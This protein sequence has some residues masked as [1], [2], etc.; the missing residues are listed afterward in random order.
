[1]RE[2]RWTYRD[3]LVRELKTLRKGRGLTVSKMKYCSALRQQLNVPTVQA[4]ITA[5]TEQLILLGDSVEAR[6]L[7]NALAI[8]MS[9]PGVL[10]DRRGAFA[11]E[12]ERSIDMVKIYEDRAIDELVEALV[13]LRAKRR[14]ITVDELYGIVQLMSQA[15]SQLIGRKFKELRDGETVFE[16]EHDAEELLQ[17]AELDMPDKDTRMLYLVSAYAMGELAAAQEARDVVR[18]RGLDLMAK[19][20]EGDPDVLL[21]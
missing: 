20:R 5:L 15:V 8:G 19:V 16:F 1:M 18:L 6:A 14:M 11:A 13:L 21:E 10:V 9:D 7:R 4:A 2:D 17:F 12:T 3:G